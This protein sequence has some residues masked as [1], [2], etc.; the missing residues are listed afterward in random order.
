MIAFLLE[1][2]H[3]SGSRP[4]HEARGNLHT[5]HIGGMQMDYNKTSFSNMS[6]IVHIS[7]ASFMAAYF[8]PRMSGP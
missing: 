1:T 7:D 2:H 5:L 6:H 8:S 4:E 3:Q